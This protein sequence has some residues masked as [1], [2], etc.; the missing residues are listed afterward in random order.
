MISGEYLPIFPSFSMDCRALTNV[1]LSS[2][3]RP[4]TIFGVMMK[5]IFKNFAALIAFP[6]SVANIAFPSSR[7]NRNPSSSP[8]WRDKGN[9]NLAVTGFCV[10]ISP[11]EMRFAIRAASGYLLT[12][13]SEATS[14]VTDVGT[15]TSKRSQMSSSKPHFDNKIRALLSAIIL[16]IRSLI[17]RIRLITIVHIK[18]SF[19]K[20]LQRDFPH[21]RGISLCSGKRRV[22][23]GIR[24]LCPSGYPYQRGQN[25]TCRSRPSC[26]V[27]SLVKYIDIFYIL[28]YN[29]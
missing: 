29:K 3:N 5:G 10:L 4:I 18:L 17:Y 2:R 21:R 23:G 20:I 6:S 11:F 22:F 14:L 7:A 25:G 28:P 13:L 1:I 16:S 8:R 27:S 15:T 19:V 24:N 9:G 26:I 12:R